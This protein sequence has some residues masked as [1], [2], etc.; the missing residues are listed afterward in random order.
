MSVY[1]SVSM[2]IW[3][4]NHCSWSGCAPCPPKWVLGAKLWSSVGALHSVVTAE[5]SQVPWTRKLRY[6]VHHTG[7]MCAAWAVDAAWFC[8]EEDSSWKPSIPFPQW[9]GSRKQ[10]SEQPLHISWL[11]CA[12]RKQFTPP[13]P[14]WSHSYQ[15]TPCGRVRCLGHRTISAWAKLGC[16]AGASILG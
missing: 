10:F 14:G 4:Q 5:P 7:A 15:I 12:S 1:L 2:H 11:L 13:L 3:E 16:K 6:L 9:T 8:V